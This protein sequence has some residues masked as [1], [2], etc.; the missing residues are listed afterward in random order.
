MKIFT[1]LFI[2]A[3][4]AGSINFAI[5]V[6]KA[7]KKEDPRKHFSGNPGT[8]NVYRM[9]GILWAA[10]VFLSDIGR[11]IGIGLASLYLLEK[12]YI[13]WICLS[14]ILGNRF[15]CFHRFQGGKGVANYLGFTAVLTPVSTCISALVWVIVYAIVKIPFIASFFM[16]FIL[17]TGTIITLGNN[18]IALTGTIFTVLLI[19]YNHKRNVVELIK[20][21]K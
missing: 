20:K 6:L 14:L 17:A 9:A 10:V 4:L 21:R 1:I 2:S 7:L 3:Y 11:A 5:I 12:V 15:P 13:P 16:I 18:S 19:Y 8:T